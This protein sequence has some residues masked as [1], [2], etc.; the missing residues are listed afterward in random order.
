MM[1][2]YKDPGSNAPAIVMDDVF[3][4]QL[5]NNMIKEIQEK[6]PPQKAEHMLSLIHI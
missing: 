4:K 2:C 1:F 3:D 6:V 5:L